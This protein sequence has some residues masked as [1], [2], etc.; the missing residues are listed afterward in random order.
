MVQNNGTKH[1]E[2]QVL[3]E[4]YAKQTN[5]YIIAGSTSSWKWRSL[6]N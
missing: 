3:I 4:V 1:T 5:D 2:V 6:S